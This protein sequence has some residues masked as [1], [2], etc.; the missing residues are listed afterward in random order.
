MKSKIN[1]FLI[2][3]IIFSLFVATSLS[4]AASIDELKSKISER[5][6]S[7][8]DLE[9]DILRYE[10]ELKAT[11]SQSKNLQGAI[12]NLSLTRK[13]LETDIKVTQNKIFLTQDELEELGFQIDE[14]QNKI[15]LYRDALRYSLK[16]INEADS[17]NLIE[18]ILSSRSLSDALNDSE[19]IEALQGAIHD[20]TLLL[21]NLKMELQNKEVQTT[22]KKKSLESLKGTLG[23]QKKVVE[24]NVK[25]TKVLLVVTKNKEQTYQKTLSQKKALKDA[26]QRELDLIESELRFQ[27]DPSSIPHK[28]A[29]VLSWPIS[30]KVRVTQK[31]GKTDF[32]DAHPGLYSGQGHNGVDF[33]A[34]SGTAILSAL[35]GTVLG[36]GNTDTVCPGASYGKWVLVEHGNGLSTLYAHLSFIKVSEGQSISTGEVVGY[37]GTTGYATGPHLHFTVY[38]SQGVKIMSRQSKVCG[39]TYRMPIADLHAYLDPLS[40]L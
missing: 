12:G 17:R 25:E 23:D 2:P 22:Q 30:G 35:G 26:F 28:G 10:A 39:G 36:T 3:T 38:A 34:S 37:S 1:L 19:N 18:V 9:K 24:E 31:F 32:S 16:Q 21:K 4:L 27:I 15:D 11:E 33:A 8:A 20:K 13:K 14:K 29:G 6:Q 5:S 7:I 40:Y